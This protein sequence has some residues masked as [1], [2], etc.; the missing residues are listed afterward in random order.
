[1]YSKPKNYY[2]AIAGVMGSGKTTASKILS[3]ELGLPLLEERPQDNPFLELFYG[4]MERWG[5]HS[6]LSFDLMKIRQNIRAQRMLARTSV[7]HDGPLG[8]N[9]IY[10]ETNRQLGNIKENEYR[11]ISKVI[12]LYEPYTI[13]P[14]PLIFLDAPLDLILQRIGGRA[15]HYEQKVPRDY[16]A[17]LLKFQKNWIAKYPKDK[18]IVI[19]VDKVDLKEKRHRDAFVKMVRE[20]ISGRNSQ[21]LS[22]ATLL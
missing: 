22:S 17:T 15:R 20:A 4:D 1:M 21:N 9:R 19:S 11:L 16:V 14:N 7:I 2:I 10:N 18:K 6:Q 12:K 8:Q 13:L 3:K 5:L